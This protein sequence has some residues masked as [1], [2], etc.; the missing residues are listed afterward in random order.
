M[1]AA[2]A[3]PVANSVI[4]ANWIASFFMFVPDLVGGADSARNKPSNLLAA[5]SPVDNFDIYQFAR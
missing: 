3:E 5:E 1:S 4:A 2:V